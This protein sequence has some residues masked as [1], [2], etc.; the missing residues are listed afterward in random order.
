MTNTRGPSTTTATAL[1]I[2]TPRS[3]QPSRAAACNPR[4]AR[5]RLAAALPDTASFD[6]SC[7]RTS[8]RRHSDRSNIRRCRYTSG[9]ASNAPPSN[10][11]ATP[12]TTARTQISTTRTATRLPRVDA[13]D[14]RPALTGR[15]EVRPIHRRRWPSRTARR[16]TCG[17]GSLPVSPRDQHMPA[18]SNRT[19][20]ATA[21]PAHP[22][23]RPTTGA[24]ESGTATAARTPRTSTPDGPVH[25]STWQ[26]HSLGRWATV[27]KA[28]MYRSCQE[29]GS[30]TGS[31]PPR[32]A[33]PGTSR[34]G[35]CVAF[36]LGLTPASAFKD[37][38]GRR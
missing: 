4:R 20:T 10:P 13:R 17:T 31:L 26:R 34:S 32:P 28:G 8:T 19:D 35:S 21:T 29:P 9:S 22:C 37:E 27:G 15:A 30:T 18:Q 36:R 1:G 25:A 2:S 23:T 33:F 5:G 12:S 11:W 3:W 38:H 24:A 7:L 6:S 16:R 14:L